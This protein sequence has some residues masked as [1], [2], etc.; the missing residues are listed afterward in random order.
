MTFWDYLDEVKKTLDKISE[1][2]EDINSHIHAEYAKRQLEKAEHLISG[3]IVERIE[4]ERRE[5]RDAE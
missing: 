4:A 1:H 5:R 2:A 3:S